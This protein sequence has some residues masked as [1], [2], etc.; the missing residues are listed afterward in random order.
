MFLFIELLVHL[1]FFYYSHTLIIQY[2]PH[3]FIVVF[4]LIPNRYQNEGSRAN[5]KPR[6]RNCNTTSRVLKLHREHFYNI[7]VQAVGDHDLVSARSRHLTF[8]PFKQSM[9]CRPHRMVFQHCVFPLHLC[10]QKQV[11]FLHLL[12]LFG[13]LANGFIQKTHCCC[14]LFFVQMHVIQD[15][16]GFRVHLA[17]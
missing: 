14:W 4:F 5:K 7:S 11:V 2:M 6:Q 1:H 9:S 12:G 16:Q 8:L 17:Q 3:S 13:H 10:I 15:L